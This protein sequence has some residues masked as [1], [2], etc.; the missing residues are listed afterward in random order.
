MVAKSPVEAL[1]TP[2]HGTSVYIPRV[3]F[4][5]CI[6][7]LFCTSHLPH[8]DAP[9]CMAGKSR[10]YGNFG[11]ADDGARVPVV[12][13]ARNFLSRSPPFFLQRRRPALAKNHT[14]QRW[15]VNACVQYA[16]LAAYCHRRVTES[17]VPQK[18]ML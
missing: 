12:S 11:A 17:A 5:L 6:S 1:E 16:A 4:E 18:S 13:S 15:A 10:M 3:G 8:P 7:L 9:A 2:S 14:Q